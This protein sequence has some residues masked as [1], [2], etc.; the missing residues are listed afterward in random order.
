MEAG[1]DKAPG[2]QLGVEYCGEHWAGAAIAK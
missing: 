2:N 1:E